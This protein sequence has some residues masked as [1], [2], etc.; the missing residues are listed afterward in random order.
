MEE[1]A[2]Q[3]FTMA[4][5]VWWAEGMKYALDAWGILLQEAFLL[6]WGYLVGGLVLSLI[7]VGL[8]LFCLYVSYDAHRMNKRL[9][10]YNDPEGYVLAWVIIVVSGAISSTLLYISYSLFHFPEIHALTKVLGG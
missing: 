5:E 6:A 10:H 9:N 3:E 7:P 4:L 1:A 2:A 8:L